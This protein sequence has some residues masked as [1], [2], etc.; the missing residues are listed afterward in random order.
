MSTRSRSIT[1]EL[2]LRMVVAGLLLGAI[3]GAGTYVLERRRIAA[4]IEERATLGVELLRGSV[5]QLALSTGEPW[6]QVLPR[7]LARLAQDIPAIELGR[8]AYVEVLD[9]DGRPLASAEDA[10]LVGLAAPARAGGFKAQVDRLEL[11]PSRDGP[12]PGVVVVAVPVA[13]RAGARLAQINGVFVIS[14]QVLAAA[15][16]RL[17]LAVL[18]AVSIVLA[19]TL[20]IYPIIR[21]LV[22][23]LSELSMQLLDANLETLQVLGS[24]I[25]KRDSDTD[26]HNHRVTVYSVRLAEASQ[27]DSAVIRRLIKGA[28]LH[29]VGKIGVRDDI[30]LK[31]GRLTPPEFEIMKTHVTHGLDIIARSQWLQDAGEVVGSHHEKY[32]GTGYLHALRREAIPLTARIFAI[33]DVFDALTS[34]RPYKKPMTVAESMA[35]LNQG[36][37]QHFDPA[38]LS[39]FETIADDLHARFASDDDAARNDLAAIIDRYFKADLGVVLAESA[40]GAESGRR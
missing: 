29:D 18:S 5:R 17:V 11:A 19:S 21:R 40:A 4:A 28:F 14:P 24:A 30:L 1:R 8:F 39:R 25:A 37:G 3:V 32:A 33:A 31:P 16:T 26:A 23:R 34:E 20:L 7:S 12:G 35:I 9:V 6:Q 27:V 10:S 15:S 38:L 13:D 36:A 2:V 22:R